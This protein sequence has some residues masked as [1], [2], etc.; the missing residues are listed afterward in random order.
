MRYIQIHLLA[1]LFLAS[2]IPAWANGFMPSGD[3]HNVD[4]YGIYTICGAPPD[5]RRPDNRPQ[6]VVSPVV[7]ATEP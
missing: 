2:A 4:M 6:T 3:C 1:M 7:Y 5:D